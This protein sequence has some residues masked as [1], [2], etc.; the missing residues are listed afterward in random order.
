[1]RGQLYLPLRFRI[2]QIYIGGP[3]LAFLRSRSWCWNVRLFR[4]VHAASVMNARIEVEFVSGV[5]LPLSLLTLASLSSRQ[6]GTGHFHRQ[7]DSVS[8]C[9]YRSMKDLSRESACGVCRAFNCKL[10][11]RRTIG[12]RCKGG[13]TICFSRHKG[14]ELIRKVSGGKEI[15]APAS[16]RTGSHFASAG[17]PKSI[18]LM[19][20]ASEGLGL[21]HDPQKC[22]PV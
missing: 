19:R 13:P 16:I 9:G 5:W 15:D 22:C 8:V 20:R 7:K 2:V 1:V 14:S 18:A 12:C 17:Y 6:N 10:S 21:K 11:L 4:R 3:S